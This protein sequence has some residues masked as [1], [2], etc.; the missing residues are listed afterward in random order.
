MDQELLHTLLPLLPSW[1]WVVLLL[2]GAASLLVA[3]LKAAVVAALPVERWPAWLR[4]VFTLLDVLAANTS[5]IWKL[6]VLAHTKRALT[7]ASSRVVVLS[8][9]D[10]LSVPWAESAPPPPPPLPPK[11]G[12]P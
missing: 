6:T 8:T 4:A 10:P 2:V 11:G 1:V 5:T 9:P 7:E 3:P 12:E